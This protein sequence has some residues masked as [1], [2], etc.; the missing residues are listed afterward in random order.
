[1]RIQSAIKVPTFTAENFFLTDSHITY[2]N[3]HPI[4]KVNDHFQGN[5]VVGSK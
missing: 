2:F 5:S 1:M 3:F 4:L